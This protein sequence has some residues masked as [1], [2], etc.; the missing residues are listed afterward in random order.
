MALRISPTAA[1]IESLAAI[2]AKP[3]PSA[4]TWSRLEPLPTSD[5]VKEALQAKVADP[6]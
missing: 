3:D 1:G 6:L 2:I 5:D 4:T